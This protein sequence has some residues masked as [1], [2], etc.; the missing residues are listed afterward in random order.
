[1]ATETTPFAVATGENNYNIT[2]DVPYTKYFNGMR[3]SVAIP[4]NNTANATLNINN[5]GAKSLKKANGKNINNLKTNGVYT[6]AYY[7]GNFILQGEGGEYGTATASQV[8]QGYSIGTEEGIVDGTLINHG[9]MNIT[10]GT[11][12]KNCYGLY[13][14]ITVVGDSDLR[15]ENI[16][17]GKNIFGVSGNGVSLPTIRSGDM[18]TIL[19]IEDKVY[20]G[21]K[22]SH[23]VREIKILTGGSVNVKYNIHSNFDGWGGLGQIYLNGIPKGYKRDNRDGT[24][25]FLETISVKKN[26]L[27]Q[28]YLW[29]EG[30]NN[31]AFN[32][33]FKLSIDENIF[34]EIKK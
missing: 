1:M 9:N 20:T 28:L 11:S 12:N 3:V 6:F 22:S 25:V 32:D 23:K 5:W 17:E 21:S 18:L 15:A 8:V 29:T 30:T 10:P 4:S 19:D 14:R 27:I 26:D 7:N 24:N 34:T 31:L 16:I 13:D 33:Y 2:L